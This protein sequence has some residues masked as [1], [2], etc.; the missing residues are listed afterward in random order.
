MQPRKL[1]HV[2][3]AAAGAVVMLAAT[4]QA[5]PTIAITD[6]ADGTTVSRSQETMLVSGT[7][8]FDAPV[9]TTRQYYFRRDACGNAADAN[10]RLSVVKGGEDIGCGGL[11]SAAQPLVDVYPA[12]DGVPVTLDPTRD[13]TVKVVAGAWL[14]GAGGGAGQEKVDAVLTGVTADGDT[15]TI[16]SGTDTVLVTPNMDVVTHTITVPL[17]DAATQQFNA[18]TLTT[19]ISGTVGRSYVSYAGDSLMDLPIMDAGTVQVSGDSSTFSA[20]KTVDAVLNG[21]GTWTAEIPV[22]TAGARKIYA[23]AV[24]GT[25]KI[26]ATPVAITVVS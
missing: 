25:S 16:G 10:R 17:D 19:T 7:A 22:P 23:R 24:Q 11:T 2:L 5:T 12:V 4:A 21:D 18:L 20:S 6:P 9:A 14:A 13:A 26:N 15:V 1:L 3:G 8:A